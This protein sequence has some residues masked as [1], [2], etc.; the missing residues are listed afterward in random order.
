MKQ[1]PGGIFASLLVIYSALTRTFSVDRSK[2]KKKRSLANYL[3]LISFYKKKKKKKKE[4]D[5]KLISGCSLP[6]SPLASPW[7][8]QAHPF[9]SH[10][11]LA[12]LTPGESGSTRERER[13]EAVISSISLLDN[14]CTRC[15]RIVRNVGTDPASSTTR[16]ESACTAEVTGFV[17]KRTDAIRVYLSRF[18]ERQKCGIRRNREEQKCGCGR[19]E[20]TYR[21][22]FV[23]GCT[24]IS[25]VARYL[26]RRQRSHLFHIERGEGDAG[27][28]RRVPFTAFSSLFLTSPPVPPVLPLYSVRSRVVIFCRRVRI[29]VEER[30]ILSG[31]FFFSRRQHLAND[32]SIASVETSR[33]ERRHVITGGTIPS[34]LLLGPWPG[35][36]ECFNPSAG[37]LS[38]SGQFMSTSESF[39]LGI[40]LRGKKKKKIWFV[41]IVS[42][43]L[44]RSLNRTAFA[45]GWYLPGICCFA[46]IVTPARLNN[47]YKSLRRIT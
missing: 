15:Q 31:Q 25:R 22:P 2:G 34:L 42:G 18:S 36:A 21:K 23:T 35:S 8:A 11:H 26:V 27:I 1:R 46:S 45:P 47:S 5:L 39:R 14:S 40:I 9:L 24:D 12:N 17:A 32:V 19:R 7:R 10:G 33:S 20:T 43:G 37:L 6:V 29:Q 44:T 13:D 16:Y 30:Q 38:S 3:D 41:Y 28:A 4:K